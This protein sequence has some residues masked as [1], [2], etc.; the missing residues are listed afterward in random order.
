MRERGRDLFTNSPL[1]EKT[2][3]QKEKQKSILKQT[4]S[5]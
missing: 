3:K 4:P 5:K 2:N 1:I